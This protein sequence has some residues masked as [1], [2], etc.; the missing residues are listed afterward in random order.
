MSV[1]EIKKVFGND[2][3][4]LEKVLDTLEMLC[5]P[6]EREDLRNADD[7]QFTAIFYRKRQHID[8][9]TVNRI[10]GAKLPEVLNLNLPIYSPEGFAH[11]S[12]AVAL[13][14]DSLGT[15]EEFQE[16]IIFALNSP[17]IPP[18]IWE[19]MYLYLRSFWF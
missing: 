6:E 8:L 3:G 19:R 4:E 11:V 5:S 12:N 2:Y 16:S 18:T 17:R 13:E 7:A 1:E 14:G 9:R 15:Y 10:I